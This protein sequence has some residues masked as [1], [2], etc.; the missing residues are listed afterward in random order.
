MSSSST[1]LAAA[2][3]AAASSAAGSLSQPVTGPQPSFAA[4]I[5]STPEPVPRSASGPPLARAIGELEQQLEAERRRGVGAGAEG[6][7]GVDDDE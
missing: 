7:A 5:A 6:L 3:S 1:P 2:F 4:A